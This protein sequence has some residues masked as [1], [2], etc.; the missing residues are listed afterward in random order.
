MLR[1]LTPMILVVACM[2][3]FVRAQDAVLY[4]LYGRGV[5]A[6]FAGDTTRANENLTAAIDAGSRDPRA[7]YFRGLAQQRGGDCFGAESDF[8]QAAAL[9][10]MDSDGFYHVGRALERIQGRQRQ[11]IESYR[12]QA[13]AAALQRT[14]TERLQ[15]YEDLRRAEPDVLVRPVPADE[16]LPADTV[17]EEESESERP[18]ETEESM[19]STSPSEEPE[20]NEP[21]MEAPNA[22]PFDNSTEP[23]EPTEPAIP[24]VVPP[25]IPSDLPPAGPALPPATEVPP[26]ASEPAL[27]P[28]PADDPFA[29]PQSSFRKSTPRGNARVAQQIRGGVRS[30]P[31]Y[32]AALTP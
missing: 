4:D 21:E 14:K 8:Q 15:R 18:L 25:E 16:M 29:P 12:I 32:R 27:T 1:F 20:T 30:A 10:V 17:P 13:R 11:I 19:P 31:R 5:H 22:D 9:E 24:D 23:M 7:F 6:Y 26:P 2:P 3:S 28:P